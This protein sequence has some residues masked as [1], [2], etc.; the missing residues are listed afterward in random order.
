MHSV[1]IEKITGEKYVEGIYKKSDLFVIGE[2]F[3][4]CRDETLDYFVDFPNNDI[5]YLVPDI[6]LISKKDI[7]NLELMIHNIETKLLKFKKS[8]AKVG[9]IIDKEKGI[10]GINVSPGKNYK[11]NVILISLLT[12]IMRYYFYMLEKDRTSDYNKLINYFIKKKR[13][14]FIKSMIILNLLKKHGA[15]KILKKYMQY[16]F[17]IVDYSR[18]LEDS[19]TEICRNDSDEGDYID[20]YVMNSCFNMKKGL[21]KISMKSFLDI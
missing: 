10:V 17:G 16:S 21:N 13:E 11:Y 1:S 14:Y 15:K 5:N 12:L 19:L 20:L 3:F 2:S 4:S 9:S 8:M 7:I 6:K 18:A